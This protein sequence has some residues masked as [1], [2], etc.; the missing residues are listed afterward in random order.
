MELCVTCTHPRAV[1]PP[2]GACRFAHCICEAFESAKAPVEIQAAESRVV[3]FEIPP[4]YA[5]TVQL[6]PIA[7]EKP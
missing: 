4:G 1:H 5:V 2:E 7:P 3:S 6:T